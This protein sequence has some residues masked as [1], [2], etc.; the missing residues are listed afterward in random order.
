MKV[1]GVFC[2]YVWGFLGGGGWGGGTGDARGPYIY[3]SKVCAGGGG[4]AR[5]AP[6]FYEPPLT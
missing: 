3:R 2:L 5:A 1:V 4:G 6:D